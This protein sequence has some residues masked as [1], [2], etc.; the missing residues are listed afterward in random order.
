MTAKQYAKAI[1]Q[2]GLS[3]RSAA[4]FLGVGDRQSRRWIA[5]DARVPMSVA[6]LL[7]L[8]IEKRLQPDEVAL[9]CD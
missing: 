9:V 2:L 7:T 6:I 8:M 3:Q 1:A 5:G 4:K